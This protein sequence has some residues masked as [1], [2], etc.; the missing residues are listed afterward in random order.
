MMIRSVLRFLSA[1]VFSAACMAGASAAVLSPATLDFG[2]Q[3]RTYLIEMPPGGGAKPLV[4]AL[5]GKGGTGQQMA[6]ETHLA[7]FGLQNGF[8]AVFPDALAKQWNWARPG[9]TPA[10]EVPRYNSVGGPPDDF[11]FL[12]ALIAKYVQQGVVDPKRVYVVGFSN[13]GVMESR[14]IC[15]DAG[16]FAAAAII[17]SGMSVALSQNCHPVTAMPIL[18]E[19]GTADDH[20]L[21]NGGYVLDHSFQTI[22]T[23]QFVD[24]FKQLD[25]CSAAPATSQIAGAK[26]NTID[27]S[28]WQT[29]KGAEVDF[30]KVNGGVH[31]VYQLPPP[32]PT[33]W[34]FFKTHTL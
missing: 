1:I 17:S 25:G 23:T 11:G 16:Q 21:Y 4:I 7:P 29:C 18:I 32:A 13:G 9:Q 10:G 27:I 31:T 3:H 14:M 6:Q 8:V 22:S 34:D 33:L 20:V 30:Y 12:K 26:K 28:D 15:D 24:F 19:K 5:H 2:G